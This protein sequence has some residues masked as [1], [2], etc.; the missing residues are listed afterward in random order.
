MADKL[1][2][3][4]VYFASVVPLVEISGMQVGSWLHEVSELSA[5]DIVSVQLAWDH[6]ILAASGQFGS[7][8]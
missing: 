1:F 7:W 2:E 6:T 5:C 3:V 4:P 8:V